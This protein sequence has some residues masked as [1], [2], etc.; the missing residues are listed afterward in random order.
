M[1][2]L[3]STTTVLLPLLL[4]VCF[5]F[6]T[7]IIMHA[8]VRNRGEGNAIQESEANEPDAEWI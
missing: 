6:F 8:S 4:V 1:M 2:I 3:S 5:L 7:A